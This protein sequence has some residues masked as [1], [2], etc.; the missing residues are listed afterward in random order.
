MHADFVQVVWSQPV[1]SRFVDR[2]QPRGGE[3]RSGAGSVAWPS[4][5]AET[6][7]SNRARRR[8]LDWPAR[9]TKDLAC[10][11]RSWRCGQTVAAIVPKPCARKAAAPRCAGA[12]GLR[13]LRLRLPAPDA[14]KPEKKVA[15]LLGLI[16]AGATP[17]EVRSIRC[18]RIRD[19]IAD[20]GSQPGPARASP[21]LG[22]EIDGC[23]KWRAARPS[24][25]FQGEVAS[26]RLGGKTCCFRPQTS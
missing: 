18:Q 22:S 3:G 5:I 7:R 8:A 21:Q 23:G 25:R 2:G 1:K 12:P 4:I 11:G 13:P 10:R 20:A 16:S 24:D 14:K 6:S 9:A 19:T 17:A 15:G 26:A